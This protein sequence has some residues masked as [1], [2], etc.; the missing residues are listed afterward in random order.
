SVLP[1]L[2]GHAIGLWSIQFG[3]AA[4]HPAAFCTAGGV[5]DPLRIDGLFSLGQYIRSVRLNG[6]FGAGS[7]LASLSLPGDSFWKYSVREPSE[8]YLGLSRGLTVNRFNGLGTNH[9]PWSISYMVIDQKP[10]T[11]G[12]WP[13]GKVS[14][15]LFA[16][17]SFLPSPST[18]VKG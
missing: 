2:L 13:L 5:H 16:P 7:Q 18:S 17:V 9:Q 10:L 6:P 4:A 3:E 15:Y 8:L 14:V 11:G 1:S 12:V